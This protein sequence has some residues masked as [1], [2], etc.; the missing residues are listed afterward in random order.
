MRVESQP[1]PLGRHLV[2]HHVHL[3]RHHGREEH[4]RVQ[5]VV[6]A[7]RPEKIPRGA[8]TRVAN[9]RAVLTVCGALPRDR[10]EHLHLGQHQLPP[11][12]LARP[13]YTPTSCL[14]VEGSGVGV[15]G[16]GCGVRGV[17][18]GVWSSGFGVWGFG[19]G[20]RGLG[21]G[22]WGL[23]FRVE[24]V[25]FGVWGVG[26]DRATRVQRSTGSPARGVARRVLRGPPVAASALGSIRVRSR[27]AIYTVR[28][29]P[30]FERKLASRNQGQGLVWCKFGHINVE[31]LTQRKPRTREEWS[32]ESPARGV[33]RRVRRGRPA[34][35]SAFEG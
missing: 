15:W 22:V 14:S 21:F 18:C 30:F 12:H 34:A 8:D 29:K 3:A 11:R 9:A 25:G 17:G 20:V 32:T 2:H 28:Y 16:V 19:F 13:V 7:R 5:H 4:G 1:S 10:S 33:A 31:I 6:R 26:S 24:G 27:H 35:A 23:G